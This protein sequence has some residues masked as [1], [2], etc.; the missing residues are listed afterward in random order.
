MMRRYRK[1]SQY[2]LSPWI[3]LP[4]AGEWT[5]ISSS[6]NGRWNGVL[7]GIADP[8]AT[9]TRYGVPFGAG[10]SCW[11]LFRQIAAPYSVR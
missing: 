5:I 10:K 1:T 11:R 8:A 4:H 6:S 3:S 7:I 9:M 2:Q